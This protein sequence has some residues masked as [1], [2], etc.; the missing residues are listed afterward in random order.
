GYAIQGFGHARAMLVLSL[1]PVIAL[2]LL[3]RRRRPLPRPERVPRAGNT[4]VLDLLRVPALR[5]TLIASG[6]L[7]MGWDIYGF[8]M[9]LYGHRLGLSAATI[10]IV[11]ST[12]ALATFTVRAILTQLVRHVRHWVLIGSAMALAGAAYLLFPFVSSVPL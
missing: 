6:L 7:N 1:F 11:M 9:P 12:F 3:W 8:L 4:G 5:Y 10:G 2:V